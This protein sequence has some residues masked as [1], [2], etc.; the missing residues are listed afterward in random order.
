MK[1]NENSWDKLLHIKTTG[2]D[3]LN[4]DEY[5][6][7]YEPT[8]YSVLER[9]ANSGYIRKR[10]VVLDYACGCEFL[11]VRDDKKTAIQKPIL[12]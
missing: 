3:A 10:D 1:D 6:H 11:R 2:R 8:P 12:T 7:P 5:R 9:F 4:T